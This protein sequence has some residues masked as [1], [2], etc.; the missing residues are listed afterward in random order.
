MALGPRPQRSLAEQL[1]RC[2]T[3]GEQLGRDHGLWGR[4][5]EIVALNSM[6]KLVPGATLNRATPGAARLMVAIWSC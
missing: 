6:S 3:T 2:G 5:S 4:G 1:L